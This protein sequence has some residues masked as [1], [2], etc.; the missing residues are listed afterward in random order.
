[1]PVDSVP[2]VYRPSRGN[3]PEKRRQDENIPEGHGAF[4]FP[5]FLSAFVRD[6]RNER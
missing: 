3:V 4:A 5:F 6:P 2:R 1:M